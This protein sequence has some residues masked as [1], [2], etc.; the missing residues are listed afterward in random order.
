MKNGQDSRYITNGSPKNNV[1]NEPCTKCEGNGVIIDATGDY[2]GDCPR[3][4][5]EG[6]KKRNS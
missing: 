4:E 2:S 1:K 5:G 6:I 3:C